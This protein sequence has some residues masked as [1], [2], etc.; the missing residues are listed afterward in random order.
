[1]MCSL[2]DAT[3]VIIRLQTKAE[4]SFIF[5]KTN[6]KCMPGK[7]ADYLMEG[8]KNEQNAVYAATFKVVRRPPG[9]RK[10]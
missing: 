8:Q 7:L 3:G 10:I 9:R 6:G 2:T 1:M 4:N 5:M